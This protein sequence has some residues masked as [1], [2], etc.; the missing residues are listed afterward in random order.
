MPQR[1]KDELPAREY[2][3][4]LCPKNLFKEAVPL[5]DIHTEEERR[6]IYVA[7]TRAR[8]RLA[9][10]TPERSVSREASG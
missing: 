9:T 2:G 1:L 6:L 10:T 8:D 7:L 3:S 5:G 4:G